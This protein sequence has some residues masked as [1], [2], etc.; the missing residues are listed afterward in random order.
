MTEPLY[1]TELSIPL[2]EVVP[3]GVLAL[4]NFDGVHRGHQAV[5][6]AALDQAARLGPDV[7]TYII[8]FEPH[9]RTVFHPGDPPFRL[10]PSRDKV[11]LL[12]GLGISGVIV[13][14]FTPE[15]SCMKAQDFI[16]QILVKQLHARHVVAGFDF[17]FGY[18]RAGNVAMLRNILVAK[19]VGVT[20]VLSF[21]DAHGE[22][23]SSSG[24]RA[25]LER[26]DVVKAQHILGRPWSITGVV[27]HGEKRGRTLGYPTANIAMR[28]YIRPKFGV[29]TCYARRMGTKLV[30]PGIANIGV[31][32]TVQGTEA[33]LEAHLFDFYTDIY[34]EEWEVELIDFI[35]S[36]Q[37]FDDLKA[38]KKQITSDIEAAKITLSCPL[39]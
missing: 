21:R 15:F 10:T 18:Q 33:L 9:S 11:Q 13:I 14:N 37:T 27:Q 36:E 5:V 26:G 28:D 20:E 19:G 32:P 30:Y 2:H 29:Y 38:L 4:G 1:K 22:V 24:A 25:A 35:R 34:D 16:E 12:K 39:F 31:R 6:K 7:P 23:M 3:G 17:V 8:T